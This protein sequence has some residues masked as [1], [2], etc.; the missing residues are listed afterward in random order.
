MFEKVAQILADYKD[1]DVSTITPE[2]T[3]ADLGIDSLDT[4]ELIMN[5]EDEFGVAIKMDQ[6]VADVQGI[7]KL[8][9]AS[10]Q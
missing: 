4:A 9:E 7:V 6:P 8:I 10:V 5:M 1:L 2:S 3:L